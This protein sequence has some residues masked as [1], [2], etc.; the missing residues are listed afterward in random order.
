MKKS[1]MKNQSIFE[2]NEKGAMEV[3]EQIMDSYN[4]GFINQ[5]EQNAEKESAQI[6]E[7]E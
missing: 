5:E 4:S 6:N 3:N 2:Y 7:L 1:E